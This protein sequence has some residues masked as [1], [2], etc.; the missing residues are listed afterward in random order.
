MPDG[1]YLIGSTNFKSFKNSD[2]LLIFSK[3]TSTQ[4]FEENIEA[5]YNEVID[6]D[7]KDSPKDLPKDSPKN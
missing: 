4:Q 1:R 2:I 3:S 7:A 6:F 5:Q